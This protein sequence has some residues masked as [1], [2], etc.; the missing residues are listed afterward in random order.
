MYTHYLNLTVK[1]VSW[2][3]LNFTMRVPLNLSLGALKD[4]IIRQHAQALAQYKA[5]RLKVQDI[6]DI[7]S[8]Q[9]FGLTQKDI[10]T[11]NLSVNSEI[12]L[13]KGSPLTFPPLPS[14]EILTLAD[15]GFNGACG[16]EPAIQADIFY[17]F[18]A[19][20]IIGNGKEKF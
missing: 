4:Q 10:D 20:R 16:D 6:G 14:N 2:S 11:L 17:D 9:N 8:L 3:Y 19:S 15:V 5:D 7:E 18:E 12:K 13:Y 1:L